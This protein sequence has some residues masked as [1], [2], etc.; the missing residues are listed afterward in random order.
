MAE[1]T[2]RVDDEQDREQDHEQDHDG[3]RSMASIIAIARD[4]VEGL[5]GQP[6]ERVA[7]ATREDGGWRLTLDVVE[8]ARVPDST[9]VLGSYDVSVDGRG[10]ILEYERVRRYSRNR[11]DEEES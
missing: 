8:L 11:T 9:S 5:L 2:R 1:G 6:V 4:D 10:E 3:R 7:A